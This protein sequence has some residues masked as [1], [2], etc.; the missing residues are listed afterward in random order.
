MDADFKLG[1]KYHKS[2]KKIM[3]L[4]GKGGV[5]KSTVAVNLA[6]ALSELY[7]D[8]NIGL[9]DADLHG[10]NVPKMLGIEDAKLMVEN[11]KIIPHQYLPNLYVVSMAFFL[12]AKD[13]PLIWRGP[14]KIKMIKQMV[15]DVIWNN[16]AYMVVDLPPG[17]GDEPL[18]VSQEF[19]DVDL[20][21]V[22]STPQE[23]A[24]LDARRTV[25]FARQ[26]NVKKIAVVENM[27][28]LKCPHCGEKIYMYGE[29]GAKRMAEEMGVKFLG[30]VPMEPAVV[31]SGDMGKPVVG[32]HYKGEAK[33][34]FKNIAN[35]MVKYLEE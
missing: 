16:P 27:S 9:M 23:V 31:E 4:S 17:T 13:A 6:V 28:Y 24:L 7:A 33:E 26:L 15:N 35:E 21:V 3:V 1:M 34:A 11:E 14:L 12:P 25:G 20:A 10:P 19:G 5:G 29:G 22:V 18:S 32:E 30:G 2:I 8:K